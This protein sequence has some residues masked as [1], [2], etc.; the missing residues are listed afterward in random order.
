MWI[1]QESESRWGLNFFFSRR[2]RICE[3]LNKKQGVAEKALASF[4]IYLRRVINMN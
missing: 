1:D 4:A 3:E 2:L